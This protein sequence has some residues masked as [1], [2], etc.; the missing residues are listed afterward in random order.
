VHSSCFG[1]GSGDA[2]PQRDLRKGNVS[3]FLLA[4]AGVA[5]S[6]QE[7]RCQNRWDEKKPNARAS[8]CFKTGTCENLDGDPKNV[9]A[10]IGTRK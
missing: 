7:R 2:I 9:A 6:I 4:P 5:A 8:S 3:V 10:V 1:V